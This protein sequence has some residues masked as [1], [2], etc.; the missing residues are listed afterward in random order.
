MKT[1]VV[2]AS[3]GSPWA[4]QGIWRVLGHPELSSS[5]SRAG[6]DG[7]YGAGLCSL[8]GFWAI[9]LSGV[10]ALHHE[11]IFAV[12]LEVKQHTVLPKVCGRVL[13]WCVPSYVA[14]G[15][16]GLSR[17]QGKPARTYNTWQ[18]T[19]SEVA[20]PL[21]VSRINLLS[22]RVSSESVAWRW[23]AQTQWTEGADYFDI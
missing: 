18:K 19:C 13:W 8:T 12:S 14:R 21:G 2:P 20:Q 6:A 7:H 9:L 3:H 10:P 4:V 16:P 1:C 15:L 23:L 5:Q 17:Q 22:L 11:L